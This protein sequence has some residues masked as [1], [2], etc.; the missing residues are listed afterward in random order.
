MEVEPA[1]RKNIPVLVEN[2]VKKYRIYFYVICGFN[3]TWEQDLYRLKVLKDLDVGA[4][5]ML[6]ENPG[7]KYKILQ[8]WN[9]NIN[10]TRVESACKL[11]EYKP[12][13]EFMARNK[14][15][16]LFNDN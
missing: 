13:R 3:T 5:V 14:Q 4:Y 15:K 10:R 16:E 7:E 8:T 1:I 12:Y 11:E 6:Y 9:N 2:G